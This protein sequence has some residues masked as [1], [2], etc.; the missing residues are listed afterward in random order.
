MKEDS[1]L[2]AAGPRNWPTSRCG[3]RG[4]IPTSTRVN[5]RLPKGKGRL[6]KLNWR[7]AFQAVP[8]AGHPEADLEGA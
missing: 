5:Q 1:Q 6:A 3:S 8:A 2:P 7:H 4:T